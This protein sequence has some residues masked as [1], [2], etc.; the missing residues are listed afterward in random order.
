MKKILIIVL[1]FANCFI[2]CVAAEIHRTDYSDNSN[3]LSKPAKNSYSADV[4]YIYPT[5]C[6]TEDKSNLC[7]IDNQQMR[8]A[9]KNVFKLQAE[10]FDTVADIYAPFYT[11][12]NFRA[13]EYSNYEKIQQ[14]T[15]NNVQGLSDIYWAL[16]YYFENLNQGRPF[17]LV[18]HSQ[19]SAI[20]LVALNDY[21][22]KHPEYYKNMVAAYVIGYPVTKEYLKN[23]PHLKFAK[24]SDDTGVIIS[25]DVQAPD[26]SGINVLQAKNQLV[27]NPIN[28]SRSQRL[29]KADKNLG[30]LDEKTLKITTP[31]IAD[32]K[33]N[34]KL[35]VVICST[36]DTEKYEIK[37]PK[38]FGNGSFHGQ[39][40]QFY[41]LNLRENARERIDK[42]LKLQLSKGKCRGFKSH[43][44]HFYVK[45]K[46][47]D[48][49]LK[50]QSQEIP[51]LMAS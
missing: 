14:N 17:I 19:G 49:R 24:K 32:A 23:N 28:W 22:K 10:A 2:N 36:A 16:D 15:L 31:G 11:Q 1:L 18:S 4:F 48:S 37:L 20:M 51:D 39:D 7:A 25:Y 46:S 12:Y 21:M 50:N 13:F 33:V 26:K 44:P 27:I 3:W 45:I 47:V 38:L 8:E 43:Q 29:A 30:S 40:F 41:F 6:T 35:G 42:F 34:K 5:V 9:S